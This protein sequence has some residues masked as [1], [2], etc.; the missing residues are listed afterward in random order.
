[1]PNSPRLLT[2]SAR[3]R[4]EWR[5]SR[6]E[7]AC[8]LLLTLLAAVSLLRCDLPLPLAWPAAVAAIVLGSLC[9]WRSG[10][11]RARGFELT[12]DIAACRMDGQPVTHLELRWRGPLLFVRFKS[13]A[14]RRWQHLVFWPD[15]LPADK[16]REL[17]LVVPSIL[18]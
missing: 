14:N 1:M 17:R 10:T 11:R 13:M 12:H 18:A 6:Q 16:R 4:L 3:C 15:T 7:R 5:P 2:P 8:V 9:A